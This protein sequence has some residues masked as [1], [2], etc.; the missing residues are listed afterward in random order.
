[1]AAAGSLRLSSYPPVS[2]SIAILQKKAAFAITTCG[3]YF[4]SKD[5]DR[6]RKWGKRVKEGSRIIGGI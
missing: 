6:K 2:L 3:V 5:S 4:S 1:M